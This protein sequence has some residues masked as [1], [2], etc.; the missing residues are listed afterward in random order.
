MGQLT[1]MVVLGL[2]VNTIT[3]YGQTAKED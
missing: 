3:K 2:N 1:R